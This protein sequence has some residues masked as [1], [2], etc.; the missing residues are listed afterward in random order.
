MATF[1]DGKVYFAIN[2]N[3]ITDP[4]QVRLN[5]ELFHFFMQHEG[6]EM[7]AK[8]YYLCYHAVEVHQGVAMFMIEGGKFLLDRGSFQGS[9]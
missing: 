5:S 6:L 8:V 3:P 2:F 7:V 9:F 1:I 4:P